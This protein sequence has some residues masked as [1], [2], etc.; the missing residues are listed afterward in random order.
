MLQNL[1]AACLRDCSARSVKIGNADIR[2][3]GCHLC[4]VFLSGVWVPIQCSI[5]FI[6]CLVANG[7]TNSIV[8]T[9]LL[10]GLAATFL[11]SL[12][13]G[14]PFIA[15]FIALWMPVMAGASVAGTAKILLGIT[16]GYC[17]GKLPTLLAI[18]NSV[19]LSQRW[20]N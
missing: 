2:S 16:I 8:A 14:F 10:V 12:S 9:L 7:A 6:L 19:A 3:R 1:S 18:L 17:A 15:L 13:Q 11:T 20:A 4:L 5:D